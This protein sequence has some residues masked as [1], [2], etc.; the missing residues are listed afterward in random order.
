MRFLKAM[1]M[2][3]QKKFRDKNE[4][5]YQGLQISKVSW[6]RWTKGDKKDE[7]PKQYSLLLVDLTTPEAANKVVEQEMVKRYQLKMCS[8]F[9]RA[10]TLLQCFNC[11]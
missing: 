7:T 10:G 3:R 11:C 5:Y 6:P 8:Q 2:K 4:K 9:N 1:R